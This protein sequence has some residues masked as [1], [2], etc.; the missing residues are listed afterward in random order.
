MRFPVLRNCESQTTL[1]ADGRSGDESLDELVS[2]MM[3][4]KTG[5]RLHVP[6]EVLG[7]QVEPSRCLVMVK[8]SIW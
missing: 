6:R 1:T 3:T 7:T 2:V 5:N 8:H 4:P